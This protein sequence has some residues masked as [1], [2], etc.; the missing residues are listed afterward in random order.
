[1]VGSDLALQCLTNLS[2]PPRVFLLSMLLSTFME[3]SGV[4][5]PGG[6]KGGLGFKVNPP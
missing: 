3:R 4:E 1:M 5:V 2:R 6:R